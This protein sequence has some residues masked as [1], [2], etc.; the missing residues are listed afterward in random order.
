VLRVG[1]P[2]DV[3][4]T[5]RN[6]GGEDAEGLV[7][8]LRLPAGLTAQGGSGSNGWDCTAGATTTCTLDELDEGE[9][10][11]VHVRVDV[12]AAAVPGGVASGTVRVQNG[13]SVGIPAARLTVEP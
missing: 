6:A 11:T 3:T 5:I 1:S 9:E 4:V 2:G 13:P 8:T 7:A 10:T 12:A